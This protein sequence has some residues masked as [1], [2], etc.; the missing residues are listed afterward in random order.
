MVSDRVL[1]IINVSLALIVILL[2]LNLFHIGIPSLG[3]AIFTEIPSNA[4]CIVNVGDE[5][6]Q[7]GDIDECCLE[8]RKQ[9]SCSRADPPFD[10]EVSYICSTENSPARYWLNNNAFNYCQQQPYW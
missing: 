1:A 8:S 2:F 3:K 9:L 10:L 4:V 6:T 7:W 5:F